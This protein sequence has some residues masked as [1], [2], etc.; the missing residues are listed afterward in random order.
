MKIPLVEDLPDL[1]EIFGRMPSDYKNYEVIR[2]S[3][4]AIEKFKLHKP[5]L[6]LTDIELL[7]ID[8]VGKT[9]H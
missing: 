2:A 9:K 5:E 7:D 8:G 3:S 4:G 1:L 6:V